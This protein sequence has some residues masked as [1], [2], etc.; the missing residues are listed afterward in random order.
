MAL[1]I[2]LI[3]VVVLLGILVKINFADTDVSV[4]VRIIISGVILLIFAGGIY[5]LVTPDAFQGKTPED[6]ADTIAKNDTNN[7]SA[8][9]TP[10][11]KNTVQP[12]KQ[13]VDTARKKVV[14]PPAPVK[15]DTVVVPKVETLAPPKA[16]AAKSE[17]S[18]DNQEIIAAQNSGDT[19]QFDSY[20]V[21][22]KAYLYSRPDESTRRN[23]FLFFVNS[24]PLSALDERNGFIQVSFKTNRGKRY[25]AWLRKSDLIS[26][27]D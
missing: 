12:Q 8:E 13:V 16:E 20:K 7:K 9:V 2:T 24:I 21:K 15:V 3:I 6:V 23:E 18:K 14:V 17:T 22:L 5:Y 25:D 27:D 10:P 4:P 19:S 1:I 11:V 26:V